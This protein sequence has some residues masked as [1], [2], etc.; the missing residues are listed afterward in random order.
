MN[1]VSLVLV[2]EEVW[3]WD[4]INELSEIIF[5]INECVG[6]TIFELDMIEVT[7]Y[8]IKSVSCSQNELK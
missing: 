1:R 7:I 2:I 5:I 8:G 6:A 3:S 4:G